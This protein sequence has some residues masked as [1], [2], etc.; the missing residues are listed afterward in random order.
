MILKKNLVPA[1]A[2][3]A[4]FVTGCA[5]AT[6]LHNQ[7][8][9]LITFELVNFPLADGDYCVSGDWQG[10]DWD[11]SKT[12]ITVKDGKGVSV[13]QTIKSSSVKFTVVPA[14]A[15]G[16]PWYP[17]TIGNAPDESQ[18]NIRWNFEVKGVA[19]DAEL[20]IT[21][22]GGKKPAELSVK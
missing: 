21:V 7:K 15:W 12:N 2:V 17:A 11:N 20:T 22:D 1:L 6:G 5:D 10:T 3:L 13:V 8:Q 14:G 9:T 4:F 19:M 18:N 16:R